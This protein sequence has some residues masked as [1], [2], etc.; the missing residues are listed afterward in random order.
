MKIDL[1][2]EQMELAEA[3][4]QLLT[5]EWTTADVRAAARPLG[6]GHAPKLWQRLADAGWLSLGF[7]ESAGGDGGSLIDLAVMVREAGRALV[8]TTLSSTLHA[9]LLLHQLGTEVQLERSLRPLM[10]G[11]LLATVAYAESAAEHKP[12]AYETLARPASGG[13]RLNGRKIFVENASV[14]DVVIVACQVA[15][16]QA[17]PGFGLFVVPR[18]HPGVRLRPLATFGH[19]LQDELTLADVVLDP[20]ARLGSGADGG[21]DA[22]ARWYH[23][24]EVMAALTSLEMIGGAQAVID[25]TSGYL[26]ARHAFGKPIGS[27]QAVQHHMANAAMAVKGAELAGWQALWRL[28]EGLPATRET[29]IAKSSAGRAY[30]EATVIAH[31][32]WGG[33]GYAEESDLHLWSRRA[34]AADLRHGSSAWHIQRLADRFAL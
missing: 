13:W 33:M 23:V 24:A 1:S 22:L 28:A 34:V 11:E 10:R 30:R 27:F 31:Q 8:P 20:G 4:R 32:L 9:G 29:A 18:E 19:D 21:P 25:Q 17:D 16:Q 7:P 12:A 6:S 26:A 5:R 3:S 15:Q 2:A 14:S